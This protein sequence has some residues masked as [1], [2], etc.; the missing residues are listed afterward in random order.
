MPNRAEIQ[1]IGTF[2]RSIIDLLGNEVPAT[3][4]EARANFPD[5]L[6]GQY[7]E[8][9]DECMEQVGQWIALFD[10]EDGLSR[11]R[12]QRLDSAALHG[13]QLTFKLAA[14][15]FE[16]NRI[17]QGMHNNLPNLPGQIVSALG[18][19]TAVLDSVKSAVPGLEPLLEIANVAKEVISAARD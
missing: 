4:R 12:R 5:G 11:Y 16:F 14:F 13:R 9:F 6:I 15:G 7:E 8:A 2:L 1:A 17:R 10:D 18:V 19:G 3:M